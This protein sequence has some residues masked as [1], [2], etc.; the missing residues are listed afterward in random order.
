MRRSVT[1]VVTAM[2]L[3]FALA[4]PALAPVEKFIFNDVTFPDGQIGELAASVKVHPNKD[5]SINCSYYSDDFLASFGYYFEF[6]E[7]APLD[8]DV[9][10]QFCLD[11]F[12]ERNT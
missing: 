5:D 2:L 1:I 3:V 9:V 12:D 6:V 7:P 10:L 8:A 4:L 11:E